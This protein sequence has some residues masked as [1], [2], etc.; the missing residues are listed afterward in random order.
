MLTELGSG[1]ARLW[2]PGLLLQKPLTYT[3]AAASILLFP[4]EEYEFYVW[5]PVRRGAGFCFCLQQNL[6]IFSFCVL[7][8]WQ[9]FHRSL[10]EG[11]ED[12][13]TETDKCG[14][15]WWIFQFSKLQE[16]GK[17]V[18]K[19]MPASFLTYTDP[20]TNFHKRNEDVPAAIRRSLFSGTVLT[21]YP[22]QIRLNLLNNM[23]VSTA[24]GVWL[25][26]TFLIY[27]LEIR[28]IV[29]ESRAKNEC[30]F[31]QSSENVNNVN[32]P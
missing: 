13:E 12:R 28:L 31:P 2:T 20:S 11:G 32:I 29:F 8:T 23:I 4:L 25:T 30:D 5:V 15:L 9:E 10:G 27:D 22:C 21:C 7:F 17:T 1:R 3:G 16:N 19:M 18:D 6:Y 26:R 24:Q 14:F